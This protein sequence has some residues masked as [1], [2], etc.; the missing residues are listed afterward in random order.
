MNRHIMQCG[1]CIAICLLW[2][3]G[4]C[5]DQMIS[6]ATSPDGIL[7]ATAFVRNC[8]A[9]TDFS[10]MVS[11]HKKSDGFR[12]DRDIIFVAKGRH[13]I[14]ANWNGP[15][16]LSIRCNSCIRTEIFRQVTILGSIDIVYQLGSTSTLRGNGQAHTRPSNR[17]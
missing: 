6:E 9:T 2:A 11:V 1:A 7:V 14:A 15:N 10:S 13:D 3:C 12:D 4:L 16:T 8:G 17:Q 5:E